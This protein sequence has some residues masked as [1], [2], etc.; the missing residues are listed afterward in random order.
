[1][2]ALGC[3]AAAGAM[4]GVVP[5]ISHRVTAIAA[6]LVPVMFLH[7]SLV[8]A[9]RSSRRVSRVLTLLYGSGFVTASLVALGYFQSGEPLSPSIIATPD[10]FGEI[11]IV[12][13]SLLTIVA[14]IFESAGFVR[15]LSATPRFVGAVLLGVGYLHD[16]ITLSFGASP[17]PLLPVGVLG[18]ALGVFAAKL[19]ALAERRDELASKTEDLSRRSTDLSKAY[20]KLRA[21]Q[22]ALVRKQQLAAIGELSAVVAHEVRNPLAVIQNAV[23]NLRRADV[24]ENDRE[25]LLGILGEETTRLNRIVDELLAYARPLAF[26]AEKVGVREIMDRAIVRFSTN[27]NLIVTIEEALPVGVVAA[28]RVLLRQAIDNLLGNAAQ[29]MPNG[30]ELTITLRAERRDAREV[31]SIV[32]SDTGEGMDTVVRD[33]ALDPFFTTR[34]TGT[35]LGLAVVARVVEAHRGQLSIESERN[36]GTRITLTLPVDVDPHPSQRGADAILTAAD[37]LRASGAVRVGRLSEPPSE[38]E[39]DSLPDSTSDPPPN[40]QAASG[41]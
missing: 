22:S 32:I 9:A 5:V 21:A 26:A 8:T 27:P 6:V 41:E 40:R 19:K 17:T 18:F 25:V 10:R 39:R 7:V 29:A 34:P 37:A 24:K 15:R 33:R 13:V 36:V 38:S 14:T 30:G 20:R 31:V 35:G 3:L 1:M 16:A 28:D 4:S 23:A 11:L 2:M 12:A